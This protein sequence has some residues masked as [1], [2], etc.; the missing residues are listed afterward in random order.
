MDTFLLINA[1]CSLGA[2]LLVAWFLSSKTGHLF[3]LKLMYALA[4]GPLVM[5]GGAALGRFCSFSLS[6]ALFPALQCPCAA[7]QRAARHGLVG[8]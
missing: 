5:V 4:L 3:G 2:I 6:L 7:L 1:G 8:V